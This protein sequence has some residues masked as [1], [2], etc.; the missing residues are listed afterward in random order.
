[1]VEVFRFNKLFAFFFVGKGGNDAGSHRST[2]CGNDQIRRIAR[3]KRR[4]I[5]AN[6]GCEIKCQAR[7]N[8][9]MLEGLGWRQTLL[10][11]PRTWRQLRSAT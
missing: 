11:G 8:H 2:T 5:Q 1:M 4:I 7:K 6:I 9:G 3:F 10:L